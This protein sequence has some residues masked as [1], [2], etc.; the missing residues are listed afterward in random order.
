[1]KSKRIFSLFIALLMLLALFSACA[2]NTG[3]ERN[4]GDN[5][6]SV[7]D[8]KGNAGQPDD[9]DTPEE[10]E[11]EKIDYMAFD[12]LP[13]SDNYKLA[14]ERQ[15]AN[16]LKC[17]ENQHL[18]GIEVE[19]NFV[20][21][22]TYSSVISSSA[23]A[24]TLPEAYFGS[25]LDDATYND[26]INRGM[27]LSLNEV[28]EHSSGNM[29][30]AFGEDGCYAWGRAVETINDDWFGLIMT[31]GSVPAI[32]IQE[33][34]GPL[35]MLVQMNAA[36]ALMI[37]QDWLDTLGLEMPQNAEEYYDACLKMNTEDV[38]GNG[39]NDERIIIGLG[40]PFQYQGIGQWYGLSMR[41]FL[42]DP[43][44]GKIE[45]NI[46]KEGFAP[47]AEYMRLLYKDRLIY[48]NEGGHPW[49]QYGPFVAE[50]NVISW[51]LKPDTLWS[52][53]RSSCPDTNCN[54]QPL[55]IYQ[56]VEGVAPRVVAQ[57]SNGTEWSLTFNASMDPKKAA[58]FADCIYS[59]EQYLLK[60][61]GI[62]NESWEY[63]E[64]GSIIDYTTLPGYVSGDIE[65]QYRAL[66]SLKEQWSDFM[67]YFP[68]PATKD[69]WEVN[70]A[71][72]TSHTD[73]LEH[74]EPYAARNLDMDGWMA[75]NNWNEESP[76]NKLM[77]NV[78]E[79]GDENIN[80]ACYYSYPALATE[81]E[82]LIQ[83][84]YGNELKTYLQETTTKLIIGDYEIA[85][86]QSYIDYAFENLYLQEYIDAQQGR[87]DRFLEAIGR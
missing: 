11:I 27:F 49:V 14:L 67:T 81:D 46:L 78:A 55:P 13:S 86:L 53:G 69:M 51:F 28:M 58:K 15:D 73:A 8:P 7:E 19:V 1:M 77:K 54:Y 34:D 66:S 2:N 23:A 48:N 76:L 4:A 61:Y 40:T 20:S 6:E 30:K 72:Y 71:V 32:Q 83:S 12:L 3:N 16:L 60:H 82:L 31:N 25:V 80:W 44:S 41:D 29:V 35:R 43:S 18:Y 45:V 68:C 26:W 59:Y 39:L 63:G 52:T 50:N 21:N 64:D 17:V 84:E 79:I 22:E 47:W 87:V 56:A 9:G 65:Y 85:D 75:Q 10:L 57:E 37:R 36:Y 38:N 70:A 62:E 33:S 74:G 5:N 42:E 24:G